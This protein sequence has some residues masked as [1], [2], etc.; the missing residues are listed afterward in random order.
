MT[1]ET[2]G[3]ACA[4]VVCGMDRRLA[5]IRR[6][7]IVIRPGDDTNDLH[8][9]LRNSI[10]RLAGGAAAD[11]GRLAGR[12]VRDL[13][14]TPEAEVA[15]R[16]WTLAHIFDGPRSDPYAPRLSRLRLIDAPT[17]LKRIRQRLRRSTNNDAYQQ[18]TPGSSAARNPVCLS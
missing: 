14:R 7:M 18:V 2:G 9:R 5:D 6:A 10:T 1:D 3:L 16:A 13:R 4:D 15:H 12:I 8:R 11:A 17:G